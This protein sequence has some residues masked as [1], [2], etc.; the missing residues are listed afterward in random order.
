MEVS[1]QLYAPAAL[2]L[3]S[4]PPCRR[5]TG[6]QIRSEICG[7][8]KNPLPGIKPPLPQPVAVMRS[9]TVLSETQIVMGNELESIWK[10]AIVAYS[11]VGV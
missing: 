9:T 8:E 10:E 7:S 6:P 2:S 5:L 3:E 4:H 11:K 1:R